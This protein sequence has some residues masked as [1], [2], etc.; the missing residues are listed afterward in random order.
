[1]VR[2]VTKGAAGFGELAALLRYTEETI[3]RGLE[4]TRVEIVLLDDS[5]NDEP[6][7]RLSQKFNDW[8]V[9]VLE[10]D[11]DVTAMQAT[12][13]YA[14]RRE[15][16]LIALMAIAAEPQTL[17]SE[18]RAV[19]DVLAGQVA[20]EIESL[21]L[22]EEKLRLER[23]LAVQERL[24]TLG[25]MATTIAHEVK[26]PLSSI[27]AIAQVMREEDELKSYDRDLEIIVKEVDRLS[28]TV[29][30]LLS[31][32]RPGVSESQPV[33]LTELINSTIALFSKEAQE[34]G[35]TLASHIGNDI[36]LPGTIAVA[37]RET[38][39]NLVLNA[40]QAS[41]NGGAVT[42]DAAVD[43][44]TK[45]NGAG[46]KGSLLISVTDAGPGIKKAEQQRVFEPFY[47]TKSRGTGLG[48]AIVQRRVAE[49]GGTVDLLSP[50]Y[51]SRG[52]RFRLL[53]PLE[54]LP[55]K[56]QTV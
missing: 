43:A 35:V 9:D 30:Q 24:A 36:E 44:G 10:K 40:V 14:L 17:T 1:V 37:L 29:S 18:K 46:Q 15:E 26:N 38:L 39:S 16:K 53:V 50:V 51:E 47:T 19:L 23:E 33:R 21:H 22:I 49:L 55:K 32:A 34:R 5:V 25:Q 27:K 3:R 31:F 48:L 45:S 54:N 56:S 8:Q 28:R 6:T 11:E 13:V 2:Q 4:L 12:A 20:I 42:V 52:T 41:D 7:K